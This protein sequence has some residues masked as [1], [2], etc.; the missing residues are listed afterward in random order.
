M[1]NTSTPLTSALQAGLEVAQL[2]QALGSRGVGR[3][4]QLLSVICYNA[5][6]DFLGDAPAHRVVCPGA[7]DIAG[8]LGWEVVEGVTS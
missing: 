7:W 3:E 5:R 1:C 8:Q 2:E 4:R 6:Q